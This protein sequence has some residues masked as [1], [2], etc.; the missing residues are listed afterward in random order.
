MFVDNTFSSVGYLIGLAVVTTLIILP[1]ALM[2]LKS[3]NFFR[4]TP[5]V[6]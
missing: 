2:G 6:R 1:L 3:R 5:Q 4:R